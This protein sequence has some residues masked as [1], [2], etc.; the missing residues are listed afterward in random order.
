MCFGVPL[1]CPPPDQWSKLFD[2][3]SYHGRV[4]GY[5]LPSQND[6]Y[7][8]QESTRARALLGSDRGSSRSSSVDD[9]AEFEYLFIKSH[10]SLHCRVDRLI[11]VS[12]Q[13]DVFLRIFPMRQE[14]IQANTSTAAKD[15]NRRSPDENEIRAAKVTLKAGQPS[16]GVLFHKRRCLVYD[17]TVRL[18]T[19]H[20]LLTEL[21][22]IPTFTLFPDGSLKRDANLTDCV[23]R[24]YNV[25]V[26][27]PCGTHV[28]QHWTYNPVNGAL[29]STT[30]G[31][32]AQYN[33]SLDY[34]PT[35]KCTGEESQRWE[36]LRSA[37]SDALDYL[38][39]KN[40]SNTAMFVALNAVSIVSMVS[41]KNK[42][43]ECGWQPGTQGHR[44][45]PTGKRKCCNR[46]T[47]E[48][49]LSRTFSDFQQKRM[50]AKTATFEDTRQRPFLQ[51]FKP[52]S[53]QPSSVNPGPKGSDNIG[54]TRCLSN[55]WDF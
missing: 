4:D 8:D 42:V 40:Y 5:S 21:D 10:G 39:R 47:K 37:V 44:K 16:S 53:C 49:V 12:G 7:H 15:R 55:T 29:S 2:G 46:R 3:R 20:C 23:T 36:F 34:V 27:R 6:L 35:L 24:E 19:K 18:A 14:P 1:G 22:R 13:S 51:L 26:L 52:L 33:E 32:C 43:A 9:D 31:L 17:G 11:P 38:Q 45:L 25:L 54:F 28:A 48:N 50:F 30:Y 41:Q